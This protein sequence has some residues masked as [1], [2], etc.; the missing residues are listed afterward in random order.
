MM[1]LIDWLSLLGLVVVFISLWQFREI[2]LLA[3]TGMILA[4]ALNS[5]VRL[6]VK[7]TDVSR[8][9]ALTTA[10]VMVVV[11]ISGLVVLVL[12][13][14]IDQFQQLIQLIPQGFDRLLLLRD[15]LLEN[16]PAWISIFNLDLIPPFSDLIQQTLSLSR[17]IFGNFL[18]FFSGSLTILL[19]ILLI[20]VFTIMFLVDP[21]SYRR[22]LVRLFPSTYRQRLD[23]ILSECET[24]V[25]GWLRGVS[26][27][28]LFIS[29]TTAIGLTVLGVPFV[30]AHAL[31]AGVF[32]L[33]PNIGPTISVIFPLSVA[34]LDSVGKAV[35]VVILYVIIQNIES[36]WFSPMIL[37]QQVSLLPAGTLIAQ[38]FFA[39]FLGPLGLVLALPLTVVFKT[40]VEEALVKDVLDQWQNRSPLSKTQQESGSAPASED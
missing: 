32:N 3:F 13:L 31:L 2:L 27:S 10:V 39:S 16:P 19:Q 37:Q 23:S 22:L 7:R 38:I 17:R 20:I 9:V 36:Y 28:A 34:L 1:K 14:F 11:S 5:L 4:I 35:A 8:W 40:C 30:F 33:I 6:I 21:L 18:D 12:P 25:L 26:I 29:S 15:R 24:A